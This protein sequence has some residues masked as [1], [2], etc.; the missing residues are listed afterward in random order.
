MIDRPERT[1]RLPLL[2][3]RPGLRRREGGQD[4]RLRRASTIQPELFRRPAHRGLR[5]RRPWPAR[6]RSRPGIPDP[7]LRLRP[8]HLRPHPR[9]SGSGARWGTPG[10]RAAI[11]APNPRRRRRASVSGRLVAPD[12]RRRPAA[13]GSGDPGETSWS[14]TGASSSPRT[15][16]A[17]SSSTPKAR[18]TPAVA[19]APASP[20]RLSGSSARRPNPC[21]DPPRGRRGGSRRGAQD[22]R[23]AAQNPTGLNGTVIRIDPDTGESVAREPADGGSDGTRGGSSPMASATRSAS[24]STPQRTRSTSATSAWDTYEEIDRFNPRYA[25]LYNS[26]WPCYEGLISANPYAFKRPR[27]LRRPLRPPGSASPPFFYYVHA[28][29]VTPEDPCS[30]KTARRSRGSTFYEGGAFPAAYDGALFFADSV[31][32]CI[33]VMR[34]R[35]RSS[36]S[37]DGEPFL[38]R[39]AFTRG[40]HR[41]RPRRN[42]YYASLFSDGFEPGSI[43]KISYDADAPRARLEATTP[44]FGVTPLMVEFDRRIG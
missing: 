35:R 3:G 39:G 37:F 1:D 43:H 4:P 19:T 18:S 30:T 21:G 29:A 33:Y 24:R 44:I 5:H 41:D 13:E 10:H 15:R 36:R 6:A 8:L 23:P 25:I 14:K 34:P 32:E 12:R 7:P 40:R 28:T 22:V 16:S 20:R 38:T 31:R 26:G 42:L 2:P 17:T 27:D 11:P 9:R